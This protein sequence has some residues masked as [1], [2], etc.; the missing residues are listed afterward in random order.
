MAQLRLNRTYV[1]SSF[2]GDPRHLLHV[3]AIWYGLTQCL[4]LPDSFG[5]PLASTPTPSC[6]LFLRA[7][8]LFLLPLSLIHI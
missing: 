3:R 1:R 7:V 5:M 6:F 2:S 8:D 4:C